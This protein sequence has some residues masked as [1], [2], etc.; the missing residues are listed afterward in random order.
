MM[1]GSAEK[2]FSGIIIKKSLFSW[3]LFNSWYTE[4]REMSRMR[5]LLSKLLIISLNQKPKPANVLSES[6][7][8]QSFPSFSHSSSTKHCLMTLLV[9]S[10]ASKG[11]HSALFFPDYILLVREFAELYHQATGLNQD[12][13]PPLLQLATY[14]HLSKQRENAA[15][16]CLILFSIL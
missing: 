8:E 11:Y 5:G 10:K 7:S 12:F 14:Q 6:S 1:Y 2:H 9:I 4:K 3:F 16:E 13:F 15:S